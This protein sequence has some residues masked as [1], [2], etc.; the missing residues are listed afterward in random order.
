MGSTTASSATVAATGEQPARRVR[1]TGAALVVALLLGISTGLARGGVE[2]RY[3]AAD[4]HAILM[5][6]G[7]LALAVWLG[8]RRRAGEVAT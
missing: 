7:L 4:L 3:V 2:H 8:C 5:V 1:W 6:L